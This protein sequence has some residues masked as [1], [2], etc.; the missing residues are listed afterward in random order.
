M[1]KNS[2]FYPDSFLEP[3]NMIKLYA[4]GAFPM[5]EHKES[6]KI[7]WFLPDVRT[8]IPIDSYHIPRSLKKFIKKCNYEVRFNTCTLEVIEG[9][10][11]REDTWISKKLM[12]SYEKLIKIGYLHSVEVLDRNELVGGLYGISYRGAFMGESMFSFVPQAS[13]IALAHLLDHLAKQKY[14]LL[15]VQ[16]Q[17]PHLAMF[18]AKQITLDEFNRILKES[19][20]LELS[21]LP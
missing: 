16:Y 21:F 13:K 7:N 3:E 14:I 1:N 6:S 2:V 20:K 8:I 4:L 19:Y 10:A 17:T 15:D 18:G 5:A 12:Q 11:S 9:C